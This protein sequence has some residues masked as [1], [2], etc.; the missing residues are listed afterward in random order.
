[1][2]YRKQFNRKYFNNNF[3]LI[4]DSFL[5]AILINGIE[6]LKKEKEIFYNYLKTVISVVSSVENL[7]VKYN[8]LS[9]EIFN[10]KTVL[11]LRKIFD[12]RIFEKNYEKIIKNLTNQSIHIFANNY[13]LMTEDFSG[14]I[15]I[16][17]DN[18]LSYNDNYIIFIDNIF[19]LR[20]DSFNDEKL[21]LKI[22]EKIFEDDIMMKK[23]GNTVFYY[24]LKNDMYKKLNKKIEFFNSEFCFSNISFNLHESL[25]SLA[26]L[27]K[28]LLSFAF[29]TLVN[30]LYL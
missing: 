8:L 16:I 29:L 10:I 3:G 5:R 21:K 1:M 27:S 30:D 13:E 15:K 7:N 11:Y 14:L 19:K 25:Y 26:N 6:L 9:T 4:F 17:K 12:E 28:S 2:I 18:I 20:Y 24:L 22:I 23:L